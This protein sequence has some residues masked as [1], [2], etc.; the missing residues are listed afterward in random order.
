MNINA[1]E[2][3]VERIFETLGR[4]ELEEARYIS[5]LKIQ[6]IATNGNQDDIPYVFNGGPDFQD[7][8]D[9]LYEIRRRIYA[10]SNTFMLLLDVLEKTR[11]R[12]IFFRATKLRC[13][14]QYTMMWRHDRLL[15]EMQSY[16]DNGTGWE[17]GINFTNACHNRRLAAQIDKDFGT[18]ADK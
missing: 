13:K 8:R 3:E 16:M 15:S 2:H 18:P 4:L 17:K 11:I 5:L 14:I 10:C 9:R 12:E 1:A 6:P 7:E